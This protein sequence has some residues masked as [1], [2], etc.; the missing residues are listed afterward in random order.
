MVTGGD[1][2][3]EVTLD[4]PTHVI[5]IRARRE[6]R[7]RARRLHVGARRPHVDARRPHVDARRP[8]VDARRFRTRSTRS[9]RDPGDGSGRKRAA[10]IRRVLAGE[11]GTA[12]EIVLANAAAALWVAGKAETL[13]EGVRLAGAAIDSGAAEDVLARLVEFSHRPAP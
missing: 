9:G 1:G 11:P 6:K 4:G 8:H 2:L 10:T 12:R 3:D 5:E 13:R 7:R